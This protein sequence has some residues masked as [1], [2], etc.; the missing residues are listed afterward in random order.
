[1]ILTENSIE[2]AVERK[3]DTLDK[4]FMAGRITQ[5]EYE[6]CVRAI[7]AHAKEE[8]RLLRSTAQWTETDR[9]TIG[10]QTT[11]LSFSIRVF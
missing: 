7:D 1:M 9:E 8:Y 6:A 4:V 10:D 5:T 3:M 2:R 11:R